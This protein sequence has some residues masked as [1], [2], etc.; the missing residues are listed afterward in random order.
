MIL[1]LGEDQVVLTKDII[2]IFS[3]EQARGASDSLAFL[4]MSEEEGFIQWASQD[5][6]KSFVVAEENHKTSVYLSAISTQ[7]LAKRLNDF[8]SQEERKHGEK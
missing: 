3:M 7:T 5:P 1:H 8:G 4:K 6:A 2:G